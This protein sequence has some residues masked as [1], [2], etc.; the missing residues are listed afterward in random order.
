ML[1]NI[2][3]AV[4]NSLERRT[5][6]NGIMTINVL[7]GKLAAMK[8]SM[9]DEMKEVYI[10]HG[11]GGNGNN[12]NVDSGDTTAFDGCPDISKEVGMPVGTPRVIKYIAFPFDRKFY[13]VPVDYSFCTKEVTPKVGW[14]L[15]MRGN[16]GY[17]DCD[18]NHRAILPYRKI[19]P[20]RVPTSIQNRKLVTAWRP[21]FCVMEKGLDIAN[22]SVSNDINAITED[23]IAETY[24]IGM[25]HVRSVASYIWEKEGSGSG[26]ET[27]SI[28]YWSKMVGAAAVK[29]YG[30]DADKLRLELDKKRLW[31]KVTAVYEKYN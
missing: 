29:W 4:E 31:N 9:V 11:G 12:N 27:H 13:H 1:P 18:G 5:V 28:G 25:D 2:Q 21:L 23:I 19:R 15:W 14:R 24:R 30:N 6:E 17:T 7:E 22:V 16:T 3:D 26:I 20:S 10:E 8:D